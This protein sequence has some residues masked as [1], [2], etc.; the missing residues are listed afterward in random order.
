MVT[1]TLDNNLLYNAPRTDIPQT[2]EDGDGMSDSETVLKQRK[3]TRGQLRGG[4]SEL[5]RERLGQYILKNKE[6]VRVRIRVG[7]RKQEGE[8]RRS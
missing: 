1:D 5:Q 3:T 7:S 6:V 2:C 8:E 4:S